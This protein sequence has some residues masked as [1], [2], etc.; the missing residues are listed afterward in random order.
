MLGA[1]TVSGSAAE[2]RLGSR[3]LHTAGELDMSTFELGHEVAGRVS[4]V[5]GDHDVDHFVTDRRGD[6]LVFGV[7]LGDRSSALRA[8]ASLD[9]DAWYLEW[10]DR[11]TSGI[12]ALHDAARSRRVRRARSWVVFRAF[13]WGE[14]AVGLAQGAEITFFD[15]GASG[16]LEKVGTRSQERFDPRCPR[17]IEEVDGRAY[18]GRTAF[19]VGANFEHLEDP[20]DIV[21]TWVD[22]DDPDWLSNFRST[23]QAE[24]RDVD[25]AA[26][27]RARYRSRDE[28]RYSLRSV[29]AHCGWVRTIWIVTAGQRPSWLEDDPRIR[30]VDHSE[31][32]GA[33][34]LPTFN[35]HAIEAALHRINDLAEHF[36]Y[37]NDDMLVARS[38]RP[39]LFFT[40]NGL[41]RV[42]QSGAR[43]PGV[44]DDS[45]LAVDTG[46]RRGR[47]LLAGRFGRVV[48]G[49]PYHSP[50][51]LR[52]SVMVEMEAEFRDIVERT[53]YSRFRSPTDLSTAASFAQ[54]YALATG[55]GV[56]ADVSTEYVNVES[57]RLDWH[58]DRIRL[59]G[60]LDTFCLNETFDDGADHTERE[61]RIR[62]FFE[63]M[64]PIAA[65]W[66]GDPS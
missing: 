6:G 38:I 58:L 8:L 47:E 7:E 13:Q 60:D 48:T 54:H 4:S 27:G 49:K 19:P 65:P 20:V 3:R 12:V 41:A 25:E 39:E 24:G 31:I 9:G 50:Y 17:T 16:Q 40:P 23:A 42:F 26:I 61:E 34:A 36:V 29:W 44:E 66:E 55:R 28:L 53:Q 52:R 21:Y 18:P 56:L 57:G 35:S 46:A 14:L 59:S 45:T 2:G 37:F 32:L 64:Y 30:I 63:T 10:S 5:L 22:G 51:P 15:L 62:E 11:S 33:D 1:E 43:P